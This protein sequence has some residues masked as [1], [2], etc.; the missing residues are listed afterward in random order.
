MRPALARVPGAGRIEALAS[1]TREI[2]VVLDP[3]KLTAAGLTVSDVA[4][5]LKAQNQLQPV[6]R[7]SQSG[8]QHLAL[9]SGL[10]S[11]VEDIAATP[12]L[13]KNGATVRVADI[14]QVFPGSP[15]RTLLI[16]GNG[17]DAVSVSISQQIGANILSLQRGVDET[18]AALTKTLPAGLTITKVYDLAEFVRSAIENVRDAILIGGLLAVVVLMLF[19]RDARLT[20]IAA[21]TLPMAVIP[22]FVFMRVFGGSINLMSMGGLA[23]AI[24][25]VIDDAVVVVENIH[26]RAS[27]G[28]TSV[29]E[30]VSEL[31][32]PLVSSTLTT[33]VV[34]APLGL[35]SGVPG[36]FFR[37]LSQSLSVAVLL[38]L[39][40]SITIVPLLARWAYRHHRV[41][42]PV[43]EPRR[44]D[45]MYLR[46]LEAMMRHPIVA[47]AVAL[48][49]A[50]STAG[51]FMTIGT[52]FLP[53]A[54][55]GGF[56]I[57][58]LTPAGSALEETDRAGEV[59]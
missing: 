52:G 22:T 26:R 1:D 53:P 30:A 33:V 45:R 39:G 29:T 55:E 11:S 32:A 41:H 18:L 34:F 56:V 20:A 44:L 35:L 13:V 14:G 27:E 23:V 57:D 54:D 24:G 2:Q 50:A 37:A 43:S 42:E 21:V 31:F 47:V 15:D 38:S 46:S 49:L 48:V 51:L 40:L 17:R 28:V 12:V 9:V 58:Y 5:A 4:A 36:Q 19:L 25:L 10:W 3:M 7:F 8:Q 6:G 59:D 16:T